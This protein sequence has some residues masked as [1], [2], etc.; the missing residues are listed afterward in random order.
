MH[1]FCLKVITTTVNHEGGVGRHIVWPQN[2][3]QMVRKGTNNFCFKLPWR[4]PRLT[5]FI[6]REIFFFSTMQILIIPLLWIKSVCCL[7]MQKGKI[8]GFIFKDMCHSHWRK[9]MIVNMLW[10][11][12]I[13][14]WNNQVF[15][16]HSMHKTEIES[17]IDLLN[18][19]CPQLPWFGP[20]YL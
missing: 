7:F 5:Q 6:S 12:K 20:N 8:I 14:F 9:A 10:K 15:P 3:I 19:P 2:A 4:I 13:C 1:I 11:R 16:E 17:F 18:A